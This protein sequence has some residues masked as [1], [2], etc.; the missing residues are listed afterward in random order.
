MTRAISRKTFSTTSLAGH[1][2]SRTFR[3]IFSP[4]R[5]NEEVEVYPEADCLELKQADAGML[6]KDCVV[7]HESHATHALVSMEQ[8][9]QGYPRKVTCETRPGEAHTTRLP[10]GL[11]QSS[12]IFPYRPSC[13]ARLK[14]EP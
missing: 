7:R 11:K 3:H 1:L 13:S 5:S 14:G 6:V 12:P 8:A 10:A 9:A 4:G 2:G